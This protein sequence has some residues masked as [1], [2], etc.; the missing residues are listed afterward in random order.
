MQDFGIICTTI[1]Q[2]HEDRCI[3]CNACVTNCEKRVTGALSMEDFDIVR[4]HEKCI[5]C[6]E[7]IGKCPTRAWTGSETVYYRM[8]IMGRTGK[9][10]PRIALP[11]MLWATQD[12]IN[13][14]LRIPMALWIATL[15]AA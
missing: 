1:P 15:T 4:D 7:C 8:V 5:G 14:S 12:E 11:F 3:S 13:N 9:R 6:G 10:N 2:Y